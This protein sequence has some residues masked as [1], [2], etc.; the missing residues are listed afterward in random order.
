ME[1]DLPHAV[2]SDGDGVR[3]AAAGHLGGV[4]PAECAELREAARREALP[5]SGVRAGK[6]MAAAVRWVGGCDGRRGLRRMALVRPSCSNTGVRVCVRVCVCVCVCVGSCECVRVCVR[7]RV[8]ES[9]CVHRYLSREAV[10]RAVQLVSE[11]PHQHRWMAGVHPDLHLHVIHTHAHTHKLARTHAH[12]GTCIHMYMCVRAC[13]CACV[14]MAG[15]HPDLHV[16]Q[17]W[18]RTNRRPVHSLQRVRE[19]TAPDDGRAC[20]G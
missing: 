15:V 10:P 1:E 17:M 9:A 5:C 16:R 8:S 14:D 2:A 13:V 3:D 20:R 19:A 18:W 7:A 11:A 6:G 12:T 4:A